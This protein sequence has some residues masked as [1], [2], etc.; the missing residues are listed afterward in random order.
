MLGPSNQ[1]SRLTNPNSPFIIKPSSKQFVT[2]APSIFIEHLGFKF[3][4]SWHVIC[5]KKKIKIC[6]TTNVE[7]FK[8]SFHELNREWHES[9]L[10]LKRNWLFGKLRDLTG[11]LRIDLDHQTKIGLLFFLYSPVE[12]DVEI[13]GKEYPIYSENIILAWLNC[14]KPN[15]LKLNKLLDALRQLD[16]LIDFIGGQKEKSL[17]EE[18]V[19]EKK[20]QNY[21]K[22]FKLPDITVEQFFDNI[23]EPLV[24]KLGFRKSIL[25]FFKCKMTMLHEADH[26]DEFKRLLSVDDEN[27]P[28]ILARKFRPNSFEKSNIDSFIK[29][30][31]VEQKNLKQKNWDGFVGLY[32]KRC[33]GVGRYKEFI[34]QFPKFLSRTQDVEMANLL[35]SIRVSDQVLRKHLNS[36]ASYIFYINND[37]KMY[38][39]ILCS[40]QTRVQPNRT[41]DYYA[42]LITL[43]RKSQTQSIL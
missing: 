33:L 3:D 7:E 22:R 43:E 26:W 29:E 8:Q 5:G 23:A 42:R 6:P 16:E 1:P 13:D 4:H 34:T 14:S 39:Q 35:L 27:I 19:L 36:V 41:F 37:P 12:M 25:S 10:N 18:E 30:G 20:F 24:S 15:L 40:M 2:F 17:K 9:D 11:S 21:R 38:T 32:F 31:D 28:S